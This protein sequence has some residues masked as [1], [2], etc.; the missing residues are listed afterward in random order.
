M[1]VYKSQFLHPLEDSAMPRFIIFSLL[2]NFLILGCS[3]PAPQ[4]TEPETTAADE[5]L[6]STE[7]NQESP[8]ELRVTRLFGSKAARETVGKT[9]TRVEYFRLN[10]KGE[11]IETAKAESGGGW[12]FASPEVYQWDAD[13]SGDFVPNL[14]CRYRDQARIVDVFIDCESKVLEIHVNGQMTGRGRLNDAV[15]TQFGFFLDHLRK[16]HFPDL[17]PS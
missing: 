13:I 9:A 6:W 17:A 10:S 2:T 4:Q 16:A 8:R 1:S 11:V 14:K 3:A 15:D 5:L 7:E 12:L